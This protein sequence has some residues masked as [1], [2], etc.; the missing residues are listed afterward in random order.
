MRVMVIVKA[1]KSSETGE[2]P[3]AQL[4]ADMGAFLR[5]IGFTDPPDR[6]DLLRS[7]AV[8]SRSGSRP[9]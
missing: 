7:F 8:Q 1:T 4:M 2:M 5:E 6:A 3:S 9:P